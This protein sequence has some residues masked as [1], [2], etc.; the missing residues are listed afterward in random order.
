MAAGAF[1]FSLVSDDSIKELERRVKNLE[2]KT[3]K[4]DGHAKLKKV[5]I[6]KKTNPDWN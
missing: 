6:K 4:N 2:E 5:H 3:N 1:S